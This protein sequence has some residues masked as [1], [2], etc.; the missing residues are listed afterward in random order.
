[1]CVRAHVCVEAP[2][3][4]QGTARAHSAQWHACR[5]HAGGNEEL[6]ARR[7]GIA[8]IGSAE[9]GGRIPAATQLVRDGDT[10]R[11][12]GV[13]VR[14]IFTPCHTRGHVCYHITADPDKPSLLFTG[15]TLF[16]GSVGKFFEGDAAT[17]AASLAK[18]TALP[19]ST[20]VYCGHEYTSSNL[21]FC[22]HVEPANVALLARI[23]RVA[24]LRAAGK[25]SVPFTLA[26]ELAT[27]VF[28]RTSEPTVQ[29]FT[30]GRSGPSVD[31]VEVLQRLREAKNAFK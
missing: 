26:E 21:R 1:M 25:P 4:V 2:L 7:A 20:L 11:V 31:P 10:I 18:L 27:N 9:E 19:A 29:T 13:P 17:M 22:A 23:E 24:A 14:V 3:R 12:A 6:A 15:D 16:G 30:H 28:L 8:I 5:D